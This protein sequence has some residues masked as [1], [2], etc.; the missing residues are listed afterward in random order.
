M[1]R[2]V[3]VLDNVRSAFNV[4]SVFRTADG[5]GATV[6][7]IGITPI[8]GKDKKLDKTS[9]NSLDYVDWHYFDTDSDWFKYSLVTKTPGSQAIRVAVEEN[10][11]RPS[12]SLFE[13]PG[14]INVTEKT[15]TIYLIFGHEINGVS[16]FLQDKSDYIV[17]IPMYGTKNS[18]NIA[19]CVGVLGYRVKELLQNR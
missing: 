2:I 6:H 18:L 4:G 13:L 5:L 10:D 7:L 3:F 17:K 16:E 9:L 8:P 12:V 11:K 19:T 15:E 1:P 14:K